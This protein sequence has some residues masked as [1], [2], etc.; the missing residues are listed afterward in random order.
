MSK[1]T[2][3]KPLPEW[4][5]IAIVRF[6]HAAAWWQWSTCPWDE[7]ATREWT[8][9][10]FRDRL[11]HHYCVATEPRAIVR[12][13]GSNRPNGQVIAALNAAWRFLQTQAR[14]HGGDA[15]S[16]LEWAG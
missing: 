12:L 8:M 3:D 4:L 15:E 1:R 11:E 13:Y 2:Y 16:A 6:H 5:E 9:R 10:H 7:Q 14:A